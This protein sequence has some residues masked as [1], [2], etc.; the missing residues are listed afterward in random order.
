MQSGYKKFGSWK[1]I[2]LF[3]H[4]T[5]LLWLPWYW[6]TQRSL[7][8]ACITLVAFTALM[9]AHELGHAAACRARRTR[10]YAIKLAAMH[11]QCEHDAAYY[12]R[13]DIFIAWGG[14]FA[15]AG[16]L[17]VALAVQY[18]SALFLPQMQYLLMPLFFVFIQ[19]NIFMAI[20]NL[21]PVPPLDGH[22]AWRFLPPR[23]QRARAKI[24][25]YWQALKKALDFKGRRRAAKASQKV[26]YELMER[27]RKK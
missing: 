20:F 10:V 21:I 25:T 24:S 7:L 26:T 23:Y 1:G 16:V 11:G 9:L 2:P 27:L 6:W 12:E 5:L 3:F 14:V 17:V 13:D 4:W 15:Q 18:A 8:W 19:V 22:K